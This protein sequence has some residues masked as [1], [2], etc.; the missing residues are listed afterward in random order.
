MKLLTQNS[1]DAVKKLKTCETFETDP[2]ID[3]SIPDHVSLCR[4]FIRF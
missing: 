2:V 4:Y 1:V 3:L